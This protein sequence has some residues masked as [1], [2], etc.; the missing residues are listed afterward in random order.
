MTAGLVYA[1][2]YDGA[3]TAYV[4]RSDDAGETWRPSIEKGITLADLPL[5]LVVRR[6]GELLLAA[7]TWRTTSVRSLDGGAHWSALIELPR[8]A[9]AA[10]DAAGEVWAVTDQGAIIRSRDLAT[11]AA[12]DLAIYG[13]AP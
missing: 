1:V 9:D 8:V 12:V 11:W 2:L 5:T 6:S 7:R 13:G 10:E 4:Y 3:S